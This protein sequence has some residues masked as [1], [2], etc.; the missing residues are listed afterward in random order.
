MSVIAVPH[1]RI[2]VLFVVTTAASAA[3]AVCASA[4]AV[5]YPEGAVVDPEGAVVDPE[6]A[7]ALAL[8]GGAGSSGMPAAAIASNTHLG[9]GLSS[10]TCTSIVIRSQA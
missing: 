8:V 10:H 1:I 7:G 2:Q 9:N 4:D 5:V 3:A 6:G